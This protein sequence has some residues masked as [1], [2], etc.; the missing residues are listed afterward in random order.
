MIEKVLFTAMENGTQS[1]HDL[2]NAHYAKF[3]ELKADRALPGWRQ[4]MVTRLFRLVA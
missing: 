1:G 3:T 4:W 2:V